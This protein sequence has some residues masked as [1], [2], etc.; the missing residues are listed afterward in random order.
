MLGQPYSF[1]PDN[2]EGRIM[3][4]AYPKTGLHL[5][6]LTLLLSSTACGLFMDPDEETGPKRVFS[7]T[8]ATLTSI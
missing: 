1:S 5:L 6:L 8:P 7:E 2:R 4:N 3:I